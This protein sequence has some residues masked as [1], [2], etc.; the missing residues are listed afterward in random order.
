MSFSFKKLSVLEQLLFG[1]LRSKVMPPQEPDQKRSLDFSQSLQAWIGLIATV[2][3][4]LLINLELTNRL[5]QRKLVAQ[6]RVHCKMGGH[7]E[8]FGQD[9]QIFRPF[10]VVSFWR[11][12]KH[13]AFTGFDALFVSFI[14]AP[15]AKS[16]SFHFPGARSCCRYGS[17]GQNRFGIPFW[18]R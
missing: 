10:R 1:S 11:P 12:T 5:S 13:G 18:G 15:E 16:N 17:G 3:S 6:S 9:L 7:F 4:I 8:G 14:Q 2:P